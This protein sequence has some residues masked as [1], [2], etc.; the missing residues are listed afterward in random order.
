MLFQWEGRSMR[1]ATEKK[2]EDLE[3][4]EEGANLRE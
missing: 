1:D 4:E 2:N 3:K